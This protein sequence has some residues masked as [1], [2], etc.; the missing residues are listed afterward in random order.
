MGE[1]RSF[2]LGLGLRV[3]GLLAAIYVSAACAPLPHVTDPKDWGQAVYAVGDDCPDITGVYHAAGVRFVPQHM[4]VSYDEYMPIFYSKGDFDYVRI[5][6]SSRDDELAVSSFIGE[7]L[8]DTF[9]FRKDEDYRCANGAVVIDFF[10]TAIPFSYF[11]N[12]HVDLQVNKTDQGALLV[13]KI[14]ISKP[15]RYVSPLR[16]SRSR[17]VLGQPA[18]LDW[19]YIEE[20]YHFDAVADAD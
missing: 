12:L 7:E 6:K 18:I 20:L 15:G 1:D 2:A 16:E 11:D 17:H 14:I 5:D 4:R 10:S 8:K 3:M 13:K 9:F 19:L